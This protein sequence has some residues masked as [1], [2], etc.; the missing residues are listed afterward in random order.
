M[1]GSQNVEDLLDNRRMEGPLCWNYSTPGE[2]ISQGVLFPGQMGGL[3]GGLSFETSL[4][5]I[6]CGEAE[7]WRA[8]S[9]LAIDVGHYGGV[10][11]LYQDEFATDSGF[12]SL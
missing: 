6:P 12:E 1:G 3:K 2:S 4:E 5:K 10:V 7:G 11:C 9:S 8:G